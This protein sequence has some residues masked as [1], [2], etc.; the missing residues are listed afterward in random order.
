MLEYAHVGSVG[1]RI[2]KNSRAGQKPGYNI[3]AGVVPT[4]TDPNLSGVDVP[5]LPDN[6]NSMSFA[7]FRRS[8]TNGISGWLDLNVGDHWDLRS[9]HPR[10]CRTG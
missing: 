7:D 9:I 4:A 2:R 10:C 8:E 3:Q 1:F 5:G 6:W